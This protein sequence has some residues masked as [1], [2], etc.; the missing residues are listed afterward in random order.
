MFGA[1]RSWS[2][3]RVSTATAIVVSVVLAF[4]VGSAAEV[5]VTVVSLVASL[6]A[7]AGTLTFTQTSVLSPAAIVAVRAVSP[8]AGAIGT[9]CGLPEAPTPRSHRTVT[10]SLTI[11]VTDEGRP[12]EILAVKSTETEPPA[13][14]DRS[15]QCTAPCENL[16]PLPADT[17]L[18]RDG[19]GASMR[20]PVAAEIG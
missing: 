18:V 17:K 13:G 1:P 2:T 12:A 14:T 10:P 6:A 19:S 3:T 20:T 5:A 8:G 16:P 11:D 9:V 4:T 7:V 15:R